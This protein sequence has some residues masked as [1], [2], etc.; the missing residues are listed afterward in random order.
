MECTFLDERK[1]LRDAHAGCHIHFDELLERRA[2]FKNE[3]LVLMH[4]SQIYRPADVH[5]ILAERCPPE[6]R[7]RIVVFAPESGPWPG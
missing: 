5:R 2:A 6:L 3:A 7:D 1:S 4:F